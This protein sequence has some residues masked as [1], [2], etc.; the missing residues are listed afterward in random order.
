MKKKLE[1]VTYGAPKLI[2]PSE[3]ILTIDQE[4]KELVETNFTQK[5]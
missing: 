1:I 3:K 4:I 5:T 2:K